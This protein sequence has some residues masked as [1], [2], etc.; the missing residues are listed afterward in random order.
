MSFKLVVIKL[1]CD[2]KPICVLCIVSNYWEREKPIQVISAESHTVPGKNI[3][4]WKQK[5]T[6]QAKEGKEINGRIPHKSG[7]THI[8]LQG[9]E[10]VTD[11]CHPPSANIRLFPR[12]TH[13]QT[14]SPG[15]IRST[16]CHAST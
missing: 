3:S 1:K 5:F 16:G 12:P 10:R 6:S 11:S 13:L 2:C 15:S 8:W 4:F 9:F 14:I 7:K